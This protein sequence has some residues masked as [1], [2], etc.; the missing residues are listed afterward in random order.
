MF[1]TVV[2]VAVWIVHKVVLLL[3]IFLASALNV[4]CYK[5]FPDD[6]EGPEVTVSELLFAPFSD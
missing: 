4:M 1:C 6:T 2:S 3:V 5:A